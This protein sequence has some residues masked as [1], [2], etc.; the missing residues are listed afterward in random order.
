LTK[1]LRPSSITSSID[2]IDRKPL[3]NLMIIE[4]SSIRLGLKRILRL[5][6][7]T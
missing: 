3:M 5:I 2:N 7:I 1:I 6:E 4:K